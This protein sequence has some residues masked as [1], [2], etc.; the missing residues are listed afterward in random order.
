MA[1]RFSNIRKGGEYKKALDNYVDYL[2]NTDNRNTSRFTGAGTPGTRG[3]SQTVGVRLFGADITAG[4]YVVSTVPERGLGSTGANFDA[5]PDFGTGADKRAEYTIDPANVVGEPTGFNRPARLTVFL[6]SGGAST[7]AQS[8][9][10][11]LY[12]AKK[13]GSSYTTPF[14]RK[15][16]ATGT[17]ER[18]ADARAQIIALLKGDGANQFPRVSIR[19]EDY[20]GNA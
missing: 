12:Y 15:F 11:K 16:S 17:T 9:F 6:P 18:F 10:T 14:G 4:D 13:P 3:K 1:R 20:D 7:Y 2:T 19:E 8:K 5:I